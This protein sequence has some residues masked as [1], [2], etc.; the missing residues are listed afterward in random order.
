MALIGTACIC[1]VEAKGTQPTNAPL[2]IFPALNLLGCHLSPAQVASFHGEDE[3]QQEEA[4]ENVYYPPAA[5]AALAPPHGSVHQH[6][7]QPPHQHLQHMM[8]GNGYIHNNTDNYAP[9]N[10]GAYRPINVRTTHPVTQSLPRA[11][12]TFGRLFIVR[13]P[14]AERRR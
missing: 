11:A 4:E 1:L 2:S 13:V 7:Y 3:D 10:N 5:A 12:P 14:I 8:S 9:Y 6:Q